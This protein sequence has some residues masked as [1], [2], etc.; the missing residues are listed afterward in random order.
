MPTIEDPLSLSVGADMQ[1][2]VTRDSLQTLLNAPSKRK[3][4][5]STS[6]SWLLAPDID[7]GLLRYR[8]L[9]RRERLISL[10]ARPP[11]TPIL[12]RRAFRSSDKKKV[13]EMALANSFM[14]HQELADLF[15]TN[16]ST[17]TR[18]L[19]QRSKWLQSDEPKIARK[20]LPVYKMLDHIMARWL[21][22]CATNGSLV[23][24]DMIRDRAMEAVHQGYLV[25]T[26]RPFACSRTWLRQI[27]LRFDKLL[28]EFAKKSFIRKDLQATQAAPDGHTTTVDHPHLTTPA[29]NLASDLTPPRAEQFSSDG[30][31]GGPDLSTPSGLPLETSE[32]SGPRPSLHTPGGPI[33]D[34]LCTSDL[35]STSHESSSQHIAVLEQPWM[36]ISTPAPHNDIDH[37]TLV[38][39]LF[40]NVESPAP[41]TSSVPPTITMRPAPPV[42]AL[43]APLDPNWLAVFTSCVA[44]DTGLPGDIS[45]DTFDPASDPDLSNHYTSSLAP[46][47]TIPNLYSVDTFDP[48]ILPEVS[49]EPLP[50]YEWQIQSVLDS[51]H[52][53]GNTSSWSTAVSLDPSNG[54]SFLASG[55]TPS[56]DVPQLEKVS[57]FDHWF[58]VDRSGDIVLDFLAP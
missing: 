17:I 18:T 56:D 50:P 27:K 7:L 2:T 35:P 34:W 51:E 20:R 9:M 3:R 26:R 30:S 39:N 5:P 1:P 14:S 40:P 45:F 41:F 31:S 8:E 46:A 24:D 55:S 53:V 6:S 28:N 32:F 47:T 43:A 52:A 23:T 57:G 11:D 16:K 22:D 29:L 12:P 21:I 54:A 15:N 33:P 10:A 25:E 42:D 13:C 19:Q 49:V 58:A 36:A 44:P 38:A 4:G 37:R 48:F